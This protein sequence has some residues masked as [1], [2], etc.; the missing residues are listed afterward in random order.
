MLAG[1]VNTDDG[2]SVV[3]KLES[4]VGNGF[5][6]ASSASPSLEGQRNETSETGEKRKL[7]VFWDAMK[8]RPSWKKVYGNGLY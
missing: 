6:I 4:H 5:K 8:E 7:S 3:T 2:H 1:A